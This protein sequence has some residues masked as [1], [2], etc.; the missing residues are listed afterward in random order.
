MAAKKVTDS[1]GVVHQ[2][3]YKVY[4]VYFTLCGRYVTGDVTDRGKVTCPEC[5][6]ARAKK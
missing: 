2:V 5:K 4:R 6:K 1:K 3:R